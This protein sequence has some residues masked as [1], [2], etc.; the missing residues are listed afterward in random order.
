METE[1]V[2][3][4]QPATEPITEQPQEKRGF[5]QIIGEFF[6]ENYAMFFAPVAVLFLYCLML[7]IF[8]VYPFGDKYT[9]ASY[10][11][12]A[13]I[14]PFIEHL[15]D[16]M[17]GKSTFTY[18]Y[19][20]VGGADV[21]GTFLYFFISP[22][23]FLFLIFGDGMVA[24]ASS[25]VMA[26]KLAAIS[27]AGAWFAK[28]L[29][30]GIP[31]YICIAVGIVYAYCGYMFVANTYINWMDFLIYLPFCAG[32][33][34][35]FVK[36]NE[37]LPFSILMACCIY[38]CFSIACFSMFTVFPTLIVFGLLCVEKDR[39]MQFIAYLCL[40]FV[41]AVLLA[42]P[43][44][45]PA[46]SAFLNSARGGDLFENLWYGYTVT[47]SGAIENFNASYF[48]SG[49]D[50]TGGWLHS[51]YAKWSY[52]LADSVFFMLTLVW[53]TRRDFKE[54]FVKFMLIAGVFT[55]LPTIVDEAMN[56][57]NMGSYMSYALRF[58]FLN[59]LYFLGGACLALEGL[60]FKP[61][62]AYDG[63]PLFQGF[64]TNAFLGEAT[65]Q[66]SAPKTQNDGGMV[67]TN[68][69][70]G[71]PSFAE[72]KS[73]YIW[74]GV[75]ILVALAAFIF[76]IWFM[77]DGNYKKFLSAF[78]T[79]SA[80]VSSLDSFSSRFAHSLGGLEVVIVFFIIVAILVIMACALV[81]TKKIGMTLASF[82]LIAV[83]GVQVCFYNVSIVAG[84]ASTQH[85]KLGDYQAVCKT[86][87]ELDDSYFRVKDFGQTYSN[88]V[89]SAVNA[90][91][92]FT[93]GTNAF[94]VF[95][96]VIDAD[97]FGVYQIFGYMGNAKNSFKSTHSESKLE[98]GNTIYASDVFGDCFLGY[99]YFAVHT[100]MVA[101]A[102]KKP[103]LKE[104]TVLDENGAEVPLKD[105][106]F[107][108]YE[109]TSVFPLGFKVDSGNFEFVADNTN[110]RSNRRANQQALY[111]YLTGEDL[112]SATGKKYVTDETAEKLSKRLW[113]RAA[114][115]EVG[116]AEIKASVTAEQGEYLMLSF[117]A[118]K[119]YTVTVNG[120]T[121]ELC[122]NDLDL[123]CVALEDGE[124][125]IVFTYKSPYVSYFWIGVAAAVVG[126]IILLLVVNKTKVVEDCASVIAWAGIIL[127]V[128]V[129]AFFMVFPTGVF[130]SKVVE[131][132]KGILIK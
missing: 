35:H 40:A 3:I 57:M 12:S 93:G 78:A 39:K 45:L 54:P 77:N 8:G 4:E 48:L 131:M 46:L 109:N 87:N 20:I 113:T 90:N 75:F 17:Q 43:V 101:E 7:A 63:T 124:N 106:E 47:D 61:G 80:Q 132:L 27:V 82:A 70:K 49:S 103:Y 118:S 62:C 104:V 44:L 15:F 11:L 41:V 19:A 120:K 91:A 32:A 13:Q 37:F 107:T 31:D 9:A 51:I 25:I 23:S 89:D 119:G 10:D 114:S 102:E 126:L 85:V 86:L 14:C 88:G 58:G 38:T 76:L 122:E 18:T 83:V 26:C 22:F 69:K 97:N 5:W 105:G 34:K 117:V 84:N 125:E 98:S 33:F 50:G 28:K 94:S 71:L 36:T 2:K 99:K 79:D 30:D 100:S 130:L 65:A 6:H 123:L 66:E 111:K 112:E 129:V 16:V 74:A 108:V 115:V 56:L 55:L 73:L 1:V 29:F 60:C 96:S 21:T 68:T 53:F 67:A 127:A 64:G 72:N 116:A 59:A 42:L 81:Y 121:A 95:S 24:H 128:L 92:P 110:S 52:I